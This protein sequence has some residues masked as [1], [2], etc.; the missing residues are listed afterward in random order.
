M[1]TESNKVRY[2]LSKVHY[3][4]WDEDQKKYG[5]PKAMPG[6]VNITF[7]PQGSQSNFYADNVVY[8]VSN[9]TATDSG[10]LEIADM[11]DQMMVDLLGYVK[12][13]NGVVREATNAKHPTFALLYQIEGDGNTLRGVRYNVTLNRPTDGAQTTQESVT[14]N[15]KTLDYTAAGRDFVIGQNTENI[16]KAHVTDVGETHTTFDNWFTSVYVF[17]A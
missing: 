4:I 6:A 17:A 2:G 3:A 11:S 9:P 8:Y 1:A 12:D 16:L 15:T 14:P 7:E 13:S 10:S 5:T